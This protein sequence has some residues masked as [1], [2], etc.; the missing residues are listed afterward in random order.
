MM[1]CFPRRQSECRIDSAAAAYLISAAS[2]FG[3]E[4]ANKLWTEEEG[5]REEEERK[6]TDG[7]GGAGRN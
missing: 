2:S 4:A 7:R 1:I 3:R 6:G 5:T